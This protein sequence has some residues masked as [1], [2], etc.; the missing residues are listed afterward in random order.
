MT[1]ARSVLIGRN[2]A[3]WLAMGAIV[4][5]M[6]A[7]PERAEANVEQLLAQLTG[8]A[9]APEGSQQEWRQRY[10]RALDHLLEDGQPPGDRLGR[11][12]A[13]AGEA[14]SSQQR[15]TL[16]KAAR[17]RL[18]NGQLSA[19]QRQALLLG[20]AEVGTDS[21]REALLDLA[22]SEASSDAALALANWPRFR[23]SFELTALA[24]EA[25]NAAVRSAALTALAEQVQRA[26]ER[27]TA[28]RLNVLAS[29]IAAANDGRELAP[30]AAA[31]RAIEAPE[32]MA[33]AA[34]LLDRPGTRHS[35]AE[36]V[37]SIAQRLEHQSETAT[38]ALQ[39]VH[40]ANV[41]ASL[42]K[43]AE[44]QLDRLA[45]LKQQDQKGTLGKAPPEDATVL[46]PY[47]PGQSPSLE[48]WQNKQWHT[49]PDGSTA[50]SA[51]DNISIPA[52]RDVRLH[53]EFMLPYDGSNSGLYLHHRYEL[54][55]AGSH[56][57]QIYSIADGDPET[58]KS[59]LRWQTC[60]VIFHA[61]RINGEGEVTKPAR[62]TARLNGK[63]IHDEQP[64]PRPTG[65]GEI[66]AKTFA[67]LMLQDHGHPV[68]YR[69]IWIQPLGEGQI[70][71]N[72]YAEE[73]PLRAM[74]LTGQNTHHDWEATTPVLADILSDAGFH[75]DTA[76]SPPPD[77]SLYGW[78][79]FFEN[80]DV[81]VLN[82]NGKAW[83]ERMQRRFETY[84]KNGGAV[85][86][87]HSSNNSFPEWGAFNRITGLG[88]WRGRGESDGPYVYYKDGELVRDTSPGSGGDHGPQRPFEVVARQPDHPI[89]RDLPSR[90]MH[91]EDE[92]YAT[93][94]GPAEQ[95]TVLSTAKSNLS[96][97]HEPIEMVIRY[98]QGRVYHTV[99]GHDVKAMRCAGFQTLLQR[100]AEWAATGEVTI[101]RP[102]D[103]PTEDVQLR[104][105]P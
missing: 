14:G 83:G 99:L 42:Q 103:F 70:K 29:G 78:R 25:P 71:T 97:R 8:E 27:P 72:P 32:A 75:V 79:P 74:I 28:G 4:V 40:T 35:A 66:G 47:K 61:P 50:I 21:A 41:G 19:E 6:V 9:E 88:G 33:V 65:G 63:L 101:E 67:P 51:A 43:R 52:Y 5:L 1:A 89:M 96:D 81:V 62:V 102:D 17:Q 87:V 46:L 10:D 93:L 49:F 86:V 45:S 36:A 60:D 37:I 95:M 100:G 57:G 58:V 56:T 26:G 12:F 15:Q 48:Q 68:R 98:G 59:P 11:L 77:V 24:R 73:N 64:V 30:L 54:Q 31:L 53:A 84:V 13:H 94:R 2:L 20:L 39:A 3:F 34:G 23:V 82:Y 85:V 80:H 38:S 44:A 7:G 92:L 69:N 55:V 22:R 76:V 104:P 18:A 90:W 16:T 91:A 105:A